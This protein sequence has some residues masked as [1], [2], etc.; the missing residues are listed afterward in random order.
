MALTNEKNLQID[1]DVYARSNEIDTCPLA[2]EPYDREW[3]VGISGNTPEPSPFRR[4]NNILKVTER[5]TN[6]FV[7]LYA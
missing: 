7:S 3:G 2:I 1:K 6:G 5:T 4:I